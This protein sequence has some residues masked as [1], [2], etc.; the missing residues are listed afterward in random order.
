MLLVLFKDAIK[1]PAKV[2]AL[3]FIAY[4]ATIS[5]VVSTFLFLLAAHWVV[6]EMKKKAKAIHAAEAEA[7]AARIETEKL[8]ARASAN[9]KPEVASPATAAANDSN[10]K[11]APAKQYAKSAVV[12]PFKTGTR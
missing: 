6:K 10:V 4:F 11:P 3:C 2:L 12:L 9:A 8:A 1:S 5:F 7:E